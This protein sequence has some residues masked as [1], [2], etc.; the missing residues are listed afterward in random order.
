MGVINFSK[1]YFNNNIKLISCEAQTVVIDCNYYWMK[2]IVSNSY[3]SVD[4]SDI[5]R[6]FGQYLIDDLIKKLIN[7][8]KLNDQNLIL[9]F[10]NKNAR[11]I[12][13]H[14]KCIKNR[15]YNKSKLI[16]DMS[17]FKSDFEIIMEKFNIKFEIFE[18]DYDADSLIFSILTRANKEIIDSTVIN[19]DDDELVN[20]FKVSSVFLCSGDSDFLAY[21]SN[22]K[23]V[24]IVNNYEHNGNMFISNIIKNELEI[25]LQHVDR[26]LNLVKIKDLTVNNCGLFLKMCAANSPNDFLTCN[27]F[28]VDLYMKT[29]TK[30]YMDSFMNS[31]RIEKDD[32]ELVIF[33]SYWNIY[34]TEIL[35]KKKQKV[36]ALIHNSMSW[37]MY[38]EDEKCIIFD[39]SNK[40]KE[41][42]IS[43]LKEL[44]D[45]LSN[46]YSFFISKILKIEEIELN[47]KSS[48]LKIN[49]YHV[50][51]VLENILNEKIKSKEKTKICYLLFKI[52]LFSICSQF[53]IWFPNKLN[54]KNL[55]NT[56]FVAF[57]HSLECFFLSLSGDDKTNFYYDN[58]IREKNPTNKFYKMMINDIL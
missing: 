14:K 22:V 48:T 53:D 36:K 39:F 52:S 2:K 6:K 51:S 24:T 58:L 38:D 41:S 5:F 12:L 54:E 3:Y 21:F 50:Y 46:L 13:K 28:D 1:S 4:D 26:L 37:L 45:L 16:F 9:V 11:R 33:F 44:N 7:F 17:Q 20:N 29:I 43:S 35:K 55:N 30:F 56:C 47:F 19:I 31:L 8:E 23:E 27:Y 42:A 25:K 34:L 57:K 15:I 18:A 32:L 49:Y 40:E 10:D